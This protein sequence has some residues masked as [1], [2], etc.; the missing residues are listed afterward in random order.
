MSALARCIYEPPFPEPLKNGGKKMVARFVVILSAFLATATPLLAC[1]IGG[2]T[3]AVNRLK[4]GSEPNAGSTARACAG[5]ITN[6]DV[7]G[8]AAALTLILHA[9]FDKDPRLKEAI[10]N[11][12]ADF[13]RR[14]C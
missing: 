13:M 14:A 8:N 6:R 11:C 1:E 3:D 2:L 12:S 9:T 5:I 4:G 10:R 7:A